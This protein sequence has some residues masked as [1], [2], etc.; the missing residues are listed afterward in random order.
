MCVNDSVLPNCSLTH[1]TNHIMINQF[2]YTIANIGFL[3]ETMSKRSVRDRKT[4]KTHR[5]YSA[6]DMSTVK[7]MLSKYPEYVIEYSKPYTHIFTQE[8]YDIEHVRHL[9]DTEATEGTYVQVFTELDP[10]EW[11]Q[12]SLHMA[13]MLNIISHTEIAQHRGIK[14]MQTIGRVGRLVRRN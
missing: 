2:L 12:W 6:E 3:K 4:A 9:I 7:Q 13:S 14:V 10:A 8:T 11:E 5:L 1:I